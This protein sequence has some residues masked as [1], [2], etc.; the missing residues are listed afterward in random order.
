MPK[1]SHNSFIS[2]PLEIRLFL[3]TFS[4]FQWPPTSPLLVPP[5]V[6]HHS[7][8]SHT[9]SPPWHTAP[10]PSQ[11][12]PNIP[13]SSLGFYWSSPLRGFRQPAKVF[14]SH[15]SCGQRCRIDGE[16]VRAVRVP[17]W[18]GSLC[19]WFRSCRLTGERRRV[20][21][22]LMLWVWELKVIFGLLTYCWTFWSVR[23]QQSFLS[24]SL[25]TSPYPYL[26]TTYLLT[27]YLIASYQTPF[28]FISAFTS[29]TA[30]I[31]RHFL[32]QNSFCSVLSLTPSSPPFSYLLLTLRMIGSSLTRICLKK[33]HL[34][35]FLIVLLCLFWVSFLFRWFW[36]FWGG[37]NWRELG[38]FWV[39]QLIFYLFL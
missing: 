13:Q 38:W 23:S 35:F 8:S 36:S 6:V 4:S 16:F 5:P 34:D 33:L 28:T 29:Q 31:F 10:P 22:W 1:Q 19:A 12:S 14:G 20:W 21:L 24:T 18:C 37:H 7:S 39:K 32:R 15:D 2:F 3:V 9:P 11:S 17:A 25:L 27:L 30:W 26:L